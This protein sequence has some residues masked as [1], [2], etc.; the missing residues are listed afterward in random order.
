MAHAWIRHS[1]MNCE[2]NH[3]E[4]EEEVFEE[5]HIALTQVSRFWR[6]GRRHC[7][8][9]THKHECMHPHNIHFSKYPLNILHY[10]TSS[11]K[12]CCVVLLADLL[13]SCSIFNWNQI[14]NINTVY[15]HPASIWECF[16]VDTSSRRFFSKVCLTK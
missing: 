10:R 6:I 9:I 13:K 3:R 8:S 11:K 15:I 16:S 12:L 14:S 4:E 1:A 2:K 7:M 5:I